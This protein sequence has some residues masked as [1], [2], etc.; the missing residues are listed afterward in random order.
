MTICKE[1]LAKLTFVTIIYVALA[2]KLARNRIYLHALY[3]L[4]LK[5]KGKRLE[6]KQTYYFLGSKAHYKIV[7]G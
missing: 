7:R 4:L 3:I 2:T 5:S 6:K 1:N